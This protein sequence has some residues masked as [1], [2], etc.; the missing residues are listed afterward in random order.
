MTRLFPALA[1]L[2]AGCAVVPGGEPETP[3]AP[4][5]RYRAAGTEPF[6]SLDIEGGRMVFIDRGTDAR[7][8]VPRPEPRTSFNGHRYETGRLTVD[9]THSEC[10]D[11]MSDRTYADTVSVMA[12]GRQYKGCGGAIVPPAELSGTNWRIESVGGVPAAGGRDAAIS[13]TG[14]R[15]SGS[16]GCNRFS[17][18]YD[19]NTTAMTLGPIAATKMACPGPAME[20]ENRLF[21]LLKGT[22]GL[23]F[24]DGDTLIL[25]GA[26]GQ[27][28]VLKR[29]I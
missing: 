10:S 1:L 20:Q 16:S 15:I 29:A 19:L 18:S 28:V 12:D 5:D 27:K 6:W 11:G 24:R 26:N 9:V 23:D 21:A 4:G 13:F 2:L 25:T 8:A 7:I 22:V 17:G 3:S 14:D